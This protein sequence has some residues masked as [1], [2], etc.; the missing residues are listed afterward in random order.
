LKRGTKTAQV[1]SGHGSRKIGP[2]VRHRHSSQNLAIMFL[3]YAFLSFCP[4]RY[5]S[6]Q[7]GAGAPAARLLDVFKHDDLPEVPA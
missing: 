7:S 1:V 3:P 4:A 6:C 2:L 5:V